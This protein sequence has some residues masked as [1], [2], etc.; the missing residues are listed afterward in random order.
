M[1]SMLASPGLVLATAM[2]VSGTVIFLALR[3]E[4]NFPPT[5][6]LAN[7]D[8]RPA[9]KP[10]L[11]SCLCS[12]GKKRE[13]KNKKRVQFAA[14]VKDQTGDGEEYRKEHGKSPASGIQ[15]SCRGG[16]QANRVAL[17]SGIL[18]DRV[19]HLECSY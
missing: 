14:S 6:F 18:R 8:S 3:R 19:Q 4:R 5:H 13:R 9:T 10:V 12:D 17:Y 2:A 1:S 7:Q 16:S 15:G 11:R